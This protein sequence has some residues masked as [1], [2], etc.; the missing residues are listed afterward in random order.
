MKNATKLLIGLA[1]FSTQGEAI[2]FDKLN[3]QA[4]TKQSEMAQDANK[5]TDDVSLA[6]VNAK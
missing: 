3:Q 2:R 4:P 5:A 6:Q 1:V